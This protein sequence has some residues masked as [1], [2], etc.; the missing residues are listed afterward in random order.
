MTQLYDLTKTFE[1]NI[2]YGPFWEGKLP[3]VPTSKHKKKF[4]GFS[5]NSPFGVAA[6]PLTVNS[7]FISLMSKL[8]YDLLTYK[9]VRSVEWH[10][11]P[12]PHWQ[13]VNLKDQ[14]TSFASNDAVVAGFNSF[15][16]TE[17]SM[18]NS[19]GIQSIKPE[20]WQEDVDVTLSKLSTGQ[21]LILSLMCTP[22]EGEK[23]VV[24]A[25]R[26]AKLA[27][28]TKAKM[29]EINLACPNTDGGQGLIYDD[30]KH[31]LKLCTIMKKELGNKPLLVKVG[32]YQDQSAVKKFLEESKGIIAGI[33]STNTYTRKIVT[34]SGK[35]GFDAARPMAGVSGAAV[36]NLSME[37][38]EYIV[39][40]KQELQLKNF[41]VVGIG[42]VTKPK[43]IDQYLDLGVDAVQ[44]AVGAFA[45]PMLA[46][47]YKKR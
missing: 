43:H 9:S 40:C 12:F 33:S 2:A 41:V 5:L 31:S 13:H 26:L 3:K 38:A 47:E 29:F 28:E 8:G 15:E 24:D 27:N 1:E 32:Y 19:F 23:L 16:N 21:L 14:L 17:P 30:I 22:K 34:D 37:Q 20:Y 35:P 46:V 18:A 11:N 39:K 36:R 45:N 4:L 6:C 25:K 7:R 44:T 10:G 42:G